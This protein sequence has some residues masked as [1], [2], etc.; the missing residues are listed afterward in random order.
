MQSQP[1]Y[2]LAT[3]VAAAAAAFSGNQVAAAKAMARMRQI[4]PELRVSNLKDFFPLRRAEDVDRWAE[5][6]R[7]AG[8]PE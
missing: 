1:D 2:I 5:G 6:M 3:S 4:D 7:K 8:L